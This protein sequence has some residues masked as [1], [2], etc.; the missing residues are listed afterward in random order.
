MQQSPFGS[1]LVHE[2]DL[3]EALDKPPRFSSRTNC[4]T[5]TFQLIQNAVLRK[6]PSLK[7]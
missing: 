3:G 2:Y 1:R 4:A 7:G 6:Q 5:T